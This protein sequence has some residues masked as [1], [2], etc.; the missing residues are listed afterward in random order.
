MA[1]QFIIHGLSEEGKAYRAALEAIQELHEPVWT[2]EPFPG[3]YLCGVCDIMLL[4][5]PCPTWML[6]DEALGGGER[7]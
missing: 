1:N 4:P 2:A 6:A 5:D 3:G 7:G